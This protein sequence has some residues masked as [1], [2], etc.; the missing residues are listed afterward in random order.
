[1][2]GGARGRSHSMPLAYGVQYGVR[3]GPAA[4]PESS[5]Q[6]SELGELRDLLKKQHRQLD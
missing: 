1:M 6:Q 4:G 2:P 3:G 5:P